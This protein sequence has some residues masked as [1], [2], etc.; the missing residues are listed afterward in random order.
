MCWPISLNISTMSPADGVR[1]RAHIPSPEAKEH[2]DVANVNVA[3][4][5]IGRWQSRGKGSGM[6]RQIPSVREL[7]PLVQFR[8]PHLNT[9]ANRLDAA[10]TIWDLRE[11]ARRRTPKAPFDYTDGA[12][13]AELSLTR[14]RQAFEDIEF[15][16][17]ILR[18]VSKVDTTSIVLGDR[19][20]LPF[21][22]APTGFTRML[23]DE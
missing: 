14:A 22:I 20:A 11:I 23:N 5:I 3:T 9:R 2:A 17:G 15:N 16:P 12:A 13:E 10:L 8:R 1:P 21:G 7:A 4:E 19:V 18:D 6:K